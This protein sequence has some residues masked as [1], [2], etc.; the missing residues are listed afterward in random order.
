MIYI[1]YITYGDY[2]AKCV[3]TVGNDKLTMRDNNN[4]LS[5]VAK[6]RACVGEFRTL[7]W[8]GKHDS[9]SQL[10]FTSISSGCGNQ[11]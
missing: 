2:F 4:M 8:M 5:E 11:R 7:M 9:A 1:C 6:T 10:Q 3:L